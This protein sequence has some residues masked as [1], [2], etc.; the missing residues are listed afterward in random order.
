MWRGLRT[1]PL[2]PANGMYP[3]LLAK[4]WKKT[5]QNICSQNLVCIISQPKVLGFPPNVLQWTSMVI[6]STKSSWCRKFRWWVPLGAGTCTRCCEQKTPGSA[7]ETDR[8][9]GVNAPARTKDP[10]NQ[11]NDIAKGKAGT[12]HVLLATSSKLRLAH[13]LLFV[14]INS[15][16]TWNQLVTSP[17]VQTH[18]QKVM[19]SLSSL[20]WHIR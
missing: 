20:L 6:L 3:K 4:I 5:G 8:C 18:T 14:I 10:D 19:A 7:V 11:T 15:L 12:N 17:S 13:L 9:V 16:P 1:I 2:R